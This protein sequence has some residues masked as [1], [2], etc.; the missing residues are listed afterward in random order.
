V[1]TQRAVGVGQNLA[2]VTNGGASPAF[3]VSD[4]SS[5]WM[6][7]NLRETDAPLAHLGQAIEV[8]VLAL[9]GQVFAGRLNYIAPSVDPTTRR[10]AVRAEID[11]LG[12]RLK[13]EMFATVR[14]VDDRAPVAI[15]VPEDAVVFEGDSARVWVAGTGK[16]LTLRQ[17]RTGRIEDGVVEVLSGLR[18]GETVVTSGSLFIDR[19]AQGD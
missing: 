10:V 13:P 16:T 3:V 9:P 5:V 6:T 4:L 1:V 17:I 19:A 8:R 11:N 14:L 12:L 2:S 7:A 15:G 18:A